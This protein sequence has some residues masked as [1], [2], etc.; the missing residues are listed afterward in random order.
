MYLALTAGVLVA[1]AIAYGLWRWTGPR[2]FIP[3]GEFKTQTLEAGEWL[4]RYHQSGRGPHLLM[5]HGI[6]ANLFCW[7][8]LVP[9]LNQKFTVT[10]IDLPGFGRSSKPIGAGYG[11]DEQTE[12]LGQILG[13]LNIKQ[14]YIVGN[15]MG[16]NIALWFALKNPSMVQGLALIAPATSSKLMPLPLEKLAWLS[17]PASLML[18][19]HAMKWAHRRTVSKGDRVDKDRVEETFLTYGRSPSAVRSFMLA[20][21]A[22]RD[23]RL[24]S[25]LK[26]FKT[27]VLILWGSNDRLVN[28]KVIDDLEAALPEADSHV[29]VG[30]GHHLQEDEPEWVSEK[31]SEFFQA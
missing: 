27:K 25:S 30:G 23:S 13:A 1:A 7:R 22:I 4:I 24:T 17:G 8:W 26:D 12:R 28:R 29:H 16:A 14:T 3:F 6:G 19:R 15:S 21:A 18:S 9:L 5:L 10:A 2:D 31:L 20:A 11:L